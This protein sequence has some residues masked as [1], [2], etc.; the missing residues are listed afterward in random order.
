MT[1]ITEIQQETTD[2]DWYFTNGA[3]IGY[4]SSGGGLLP[5]KVSD[6]LENLMESADFFWNLPVIS[7]FIIN[8]QL[9]EITRVKVVT[10][11]YL[12]MYIYMAERGIFAFDKTMVNR[13]F[14]TSYHWVAKPTRPLTYDEL[15]QNI[16]DIILK[17]AIINPHIEYLDVSLL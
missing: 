2:F 16:A 7:G 3:N 15:P 6:S 11:M 1:I 12:G 10:D 5:A 9:K 13:F 8:K 4:V 17:S 14:D